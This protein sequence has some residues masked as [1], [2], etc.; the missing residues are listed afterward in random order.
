MPRSKYKKWMSRYISYSKMRRKTK[1]KRRS[2]TR[3]L[4]RLLGKLD[5]V[6]TE[7]QKNEVSFPISTKDG[8]QIETIRTVLE[9]QSEKFYKGVRPQSAIVSLDKPYLRSIVRGKEVKPVEFGAKVHKL[10]I[11]GI[12][13]IE[14]QNFDAFNEG[15]RVSQTLYKAKSLTHKKVKLFGA[16][17]IYATN[18]NR[19]HLSSQAIQ[20]D[21]KIK[22]KPGR[23]HHH[24]SQ[25]AK[26][27]TKERAS[28]LEG[29]FGTAKNTFS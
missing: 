19:K 8:Q 5:G 24:K 3:G 9:Q 25:L 12:G 7:L 4:L 17:A 14:H 16:D 15:T 23:H 10:Q 2:L 29:S 27:I 20:T 21:F 6:L 13:F 11:D 26:M 18:K 22:G 28:K 1:I